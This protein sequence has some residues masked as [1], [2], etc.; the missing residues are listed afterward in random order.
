MG[1]AA[2]LLRQAKIP[3][4]SKPLLQP[5]WLGGVGFWRARGHVIGDGAIEATI[6]RGVEVGWRGAFMGNWGTFQLS[7]GNWTKR[8]DGHFRFSITQTFSI[9]FPLQ[10]VP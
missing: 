10:R 7:V 9:G 2:S 1:A 5:R 4:S 6:M 3:R 8:S